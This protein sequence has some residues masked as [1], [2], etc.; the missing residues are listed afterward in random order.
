MATIAATLHRGFAF[1][2]SPK[3]LAP[4]K[5]LD[6]VRR[7]ISMEP[8]NPNGAETFDVADRDRYAAVISITS[9]CILKAVFLY[10]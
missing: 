10:L 9:A 4:G 3:L 7:K 5:K 2:F 1:Q 8:G 6:E